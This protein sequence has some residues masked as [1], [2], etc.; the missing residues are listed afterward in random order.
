M[1]TATEPTTTVPANTRPRPVDQL[2]SLRGPR[3]P[4]HP[5]IEERFK[6]DKASWKALVEAVF[7]N[8]TSTES[9]IL[10]LSYCRARKLDPFKRN[11]HIV[12]IWSKD[13]NCYV[14]TIWPG[15]GEL[16]T[17]AFRTG[18]YAGRGQTEFGPDVTK[19]IG[20]VELTFPEWAQVT[21]FRMVKGLRVEFAGP[22]VYWQET[23]AETKRTDPTPNDMWRNRPRG[24]IDKCAE[25]AALRAAFPEE[26]GGDY[27]PE[28]VQHLG[29]Q[30]VDS[31]SVESQPVN[32]LEELTER[33]ESQPATSEGA[34]PT[35]DEHT[36]SVESPWDQ[37]AAE[38]A[39]CDVIGGLTL[40]YDRYFAPDVTIEWTPEQASEATKVRDE[41]ANQ[42]RHAR[43]AKSGGKAS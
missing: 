41:R 12:P 14:D 37:Y 17:T 9:I 38:I 5:A 25:A 29:V 7:P 1:A 13:Q 20:T 36:S 19:K 33:L 22:R 35:S 21:V 27:V 18:E 8:A 2:P 23:Y 31:V 26:C 3:L 34:T 40:I 24:Q 30:T 10:A 6:I 11:V 28:E 15:I 4:Y 16:R 43:N 39:A 32:G 42:L